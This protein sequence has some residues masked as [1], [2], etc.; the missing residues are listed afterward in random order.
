MRGAILKLHCHLKRSDSAMAVFSSNKVKLLSV[1]L[2]LF[3]VTGILVLRGLPPFAAF[4][5]T[6]LLSALALNLVQRV[7]QLWPLIRGRIIRKT[8][9][10]LIRYRRYAAPPPGVEFV[11]TT[12]AII[13]VL[14]VFAFLVTGGGTASEIAWKC[15]LGILV[16]SGAAE[17][18][19]RGIS[20]AKR[21]WTKTLGKVFIAGLIALAAVASNAVARH[22]A[23]GITHEDPKFFIGFV[24]AVSLVC[25][26]F[27]LAG[28]LALLIMIIVGL[29]TIVYFFVRATFNVLWVLKIV[30]VSFAERLV[31]LG[32]RGIRGD[33]SDL[34]RGLTFFWR[35]ASLAGLGLCVVLIEG[36]VLVEPPPL[37]DH[38]ARI[39]IVALDY[40]AG[41]SCI[42]G[43]QL[44]GAGLDE[45][46]FSIAAPLK[47][48]MVFATE[49]CRPAQNSAPNL[50]ASR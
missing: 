7:S 13:A 50:P 31:N 43:S 42:T 45:G 27:V 34:N 47:N 17:C 15:I 49:R 21:A 40:D 32:T 46:R 30:R 10:L 12:V 22:A 38:L 14:G 4:L 41:H 26:P 35:A 19:A 33:T 28:M 3:G 39:G 25:L 1:G 11:A 5:T 16:L 29:E 24:N 18:A 8:W 37:I 23:Y 48:T 20:M 2:T 44:L 36:H 9:R 6:I